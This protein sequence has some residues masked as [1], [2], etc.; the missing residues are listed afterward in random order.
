MFTSIMHEREELQIKTGYDYCQYYKLGDVIPWTPDHHW[1]GSAIDGI[2][3]SW[4][5]KGRGPWVIIQ[6]STVV[7]IEPA[8]TLYTDLEAK[9]VIQPPARDLWTEEQWAAKAQ[10]EADA[11]QRYKEWCETHNYDPN[12]PEAPFRYFMHCKLNEK[13]FVHQI[14]PATEA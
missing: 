8:E 1:P 10:C 11:D 6:N 4:T 12:G 14:L 3:D 2:H 5:I 9:Y 7:A 13:S